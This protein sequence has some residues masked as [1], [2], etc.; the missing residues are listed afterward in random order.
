[1]GEVIPPGAIDEIRNMGEKFIGGK[2]N[3]SY[4]ESPF[5]RQQLQDALKINTKQI[6]MS[7]LD[8][9]Q[10]DFDYSK[11]ADNLGIGTPAK[12]DALKEII[13]QKGFDNLRDTVE[14]LKSAQS[15]NFTDPS[16]FLLRR[17][18]LGGVAALGGGALFMLG[19]GLGLFGGIA[20]AV[21]GRKAGSIFADPKASSKLLGIMT[22]AERKAAMNPDTLGRFIAGPNQPSILG[23]VD[24]TE[25][26]GK[27][28]GPNRSRQLANFM[29]YFDSEN[30]DQVR[31]DPDKVTLNDVNDYIGR[32]SPTVDTPQLNIFQLP[33]DV[34]ESA[35]P[36][37][38]YFKYAPEDQRDKMLETLKGLNAGEQQ[39]DAEDAELEKIP[40][41]QPQPN[42]TMQPPTEV[43]DTPAE[44]PDNT[45][46]NMNQGR[47]SFSFLFPGDTTGQAIAQKDQN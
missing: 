20:T 6:N 22:E 33:D 21:I 9:I 24:P 46:S 16:T 15:I 44:V 40:D 28:F 13:G 8:L 25:P 7:K 27:Y 3:P 45:Q 26:L 19:G 35:F 14:I 38:L 41:A 29:N 10:G 36:E 11:F 18:G 39:I 5:V 37:A 30:K 12:E 23:M 17:A 2:L 47:Q 43:P 42:T 32:L 34:L 1:M 31:V 4:I